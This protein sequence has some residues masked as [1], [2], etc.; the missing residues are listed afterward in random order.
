MR[1]VIVLA[2][3]AW[4]AVITAQ[5]A[6]LT[7]PANYKLQF[8][9]EWVRITSVRYEPL[10]KLPGH[11]HTA[12][13]TAY[14]YLNDAP[15]VL[16][17]HIGGRNSVVTRPAT[18][19]GAFRV[20]RGVDEMHAV[21]NTGD[22]ASEFLRVELKTAVVEPNTFRGRFERPTTVHATPVIHVDHPLVSISR[23]WVSPSQETEVRAGATPLLVIALHDAAGLRRGQPRWIDAAGSTRL[24]NDTEAAVDFLKFEFR[25]QP[26]VTAAP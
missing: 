10:Q 18:K 25:T 2:A 3:L 21:E 4:P 9:N 5:D 22:T 17:R 8:E 19:A 26:R 7:L 24:Q 20:F 11:S 16:F 13:P 15:P 23:M 12:M 14:V 1:F 6:F